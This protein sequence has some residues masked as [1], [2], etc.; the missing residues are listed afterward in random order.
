LTATAARETALLC[1]R[2]ALEKKAYDLTLID[3]GPSSS[4]ADYFLICTGRS[5]TQVQAI[6]QS[7]EENLAAIGI[8]PRSIE[9][10]GRS[11]WVLMDYGDVVVH[12]FQEEA[13][14][15]YDLERLWARCP[16][17]T[18]PEPYRSQARDLHLVG[19]A[20]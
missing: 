15:F 13:R 11:Q 10:L 18:L 17:V 12:V 1:V 8:R 16:V 19:A 14:S 20:R 3:I 4:I 2:Y 9:G 6:A 7:I 5:D